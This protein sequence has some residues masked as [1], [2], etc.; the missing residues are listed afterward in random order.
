ML[1]NETRYRE[2]AAEARRLAERMVFREARDQ[3]LRVA[4]A[5]EH[6]A[7]RLRERDFGHRNAA[8]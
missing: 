5:F 8:D 3:L 2:K 7:R 6:L 4:Q 1:Q